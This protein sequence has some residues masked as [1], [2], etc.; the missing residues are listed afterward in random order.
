MKFLVALFALVL[1]A[2]PPPPVEICNNG[3]DDD[4]NDASDCNDEA[5]AQDP[6]CVVVG[7]CPVD[8]NTP[9]I[10][11]RGNTTEELGVGTEIQ[12]FLCPQFDND[13][14]RV[15]VPDPGSIIIVTLTMETN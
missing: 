14:F 12:G 15:N 4:E 6:S 5:C 1:A 10:E 13:G 2:C 7:V 9:L 8:L 3:L 11:G